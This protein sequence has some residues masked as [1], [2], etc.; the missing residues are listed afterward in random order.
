MEWGREEEG[1]AKK[2]APV[3]ALALP[4]LGLS[5][6]RCERRCWALVSGFQSRLSLR[7]PDFLGPTLTYPQAGR[8]AWESRFSG[9]PHVILLHT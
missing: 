4:L 5:F 1:K 7:I 9:T 3:P 6:C 8:G 2:G